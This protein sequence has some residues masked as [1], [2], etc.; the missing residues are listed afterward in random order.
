MPMDLSADTPHLSVEEPGAYGL[1]VLREDG[2]VVHTEDFTLR[3]RPRHRDG[4]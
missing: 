1:L 2:I 4:A 3:A